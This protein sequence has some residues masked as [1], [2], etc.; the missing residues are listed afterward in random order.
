MKMLAVCLALICNLAGAQMLPIGGIPISSGGSNPTP[1]LIQMLST[2]ANPAASGAPNGNAYKIFIA[3]TGAG[4]TV[5]L[6]VTGLHGHALTI[7]DSA[8]DTIPASVCTADNGTSNGLTNIYAF[9]PSTG[10]TS[11]TAT[12]GAAFAQ[13]FDWVVAEYNNISTVTSQGSNCQAGLTAT[14]GVVT[15]TGFTPTNNNAT[16]GNLIFN[17]TALANGTNTPAC[18][19]SSYTPATGYTLLAGDVSTWLN[20]DGYGFQKSAQYQVQTTSASAV[21]TMTMGGENCSG[22]NGDAFNTASIA[23]KVGTAGISNPSTIHVVRSVQ[24]TSTSFGG[25]TLPATFVVPTPTAG[26]LRV[27]MFEGVNTGGFVSNSTT[28][29]SSDGCNYTQVASGTAQPIMFYAQNCSPCAT[30]TATFTNTPGAALGNTGGRWYDVENAAASSFQNKA[31]ADPACSSS[32]SSANNPTLTPAN[33]AGLSLAMLE[34]G[35]G[36]TTGISLPTG[37]VYLCPTY[38]NQN[39]NDTMCSGDAHGYFI[40][41][42]NAAQ[43]WDWSITSHAGNNCASFVAAFQ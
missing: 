22:G 21:P 20:G 35:T 2:T 36:P 7:T 26:N 5:I 14:A 32:T 31:D 9:Q 17:Y 34:M 42:S 12:A 1:N 41:S 28:V 4:D 37:A 8:S 15:P 13:P 43:A 16:G 29:T 19:A 39:D 30:C 40:Y 23:L 24:I 11:I 10:V 3:P 27:F 18:N 38:T 6:A 33:S 25:P